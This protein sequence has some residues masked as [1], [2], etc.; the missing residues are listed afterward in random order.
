MERNFTRGQKYA[1]V[2]TNRLYRTFAQYILWIQK[3]KK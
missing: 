2:V 3:I 1:R